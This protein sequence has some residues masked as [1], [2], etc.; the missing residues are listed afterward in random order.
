M[1]ISELKKQFPKSI[2]K[3]KQ[4][5]NECFIKQYTS[6]LQNVPEEMKAEIEKQDIPVMSDEA[7]EGFIAFY[8]RRLL[9]FFDSQYI[10]IY[11]RCDE[12]GGGAEVNEEVPTYSGNTRQEAESQA[13]ERAFE[14]LEGKL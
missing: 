7:L 14:I 10:Y 11:S 4:W 13:F 5:G 9:D 8:P 6:H 1:T 2:I 3:L 12:H